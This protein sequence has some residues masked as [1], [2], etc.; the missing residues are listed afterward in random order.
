MTSRDGALAGPLALKEPGSPEW[1]WQVVQ[2]LKEQ[3]RHVAEQWDVADTAL[4]QLREAEAWNKIPPDQPYGSLDAMCRAEVG[5][6]LRAVRK[7]ITDASERARAL[8]GKTVRKRGRPS[9][10]S[11]ENA[12]SI[13]IADD[14]RYGTSADYLTRRIARDRPDIL[15][16]MAAGEFPSARAAA[17]EAGI[18]HRTVTVRL[19][20]A[21][22]ARIL[23]KHMTPDQLSTLARLLVEG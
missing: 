19:D 8:T 13:S 11:T 23:R 3:M 21:A 15:G 14:R 22:A 18:V 10:A 17:L 5:M 1:C 12:N 2:V 7:Q 16:R 20:P 9:L 6:P 4:S